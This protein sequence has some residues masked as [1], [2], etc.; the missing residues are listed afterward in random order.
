MTTIVTQYKSEPILARFCIDTRRMMTKYMFFALFSFIKTK[1]DLR[2]MVVGQTDMIISLMFV[3]MV[4]SFMVRNMIFMKF[5]IVFQAMTPDL[6][7]LVNLLSILMKKLLQNKT[8]NFNIVSLYISFSL[9]AICATQ[10]GRIIYV[11]SNI[12]RTLVE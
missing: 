5:G 12:N 10:I 1:Q 8:V 6:F 4:I 3:W 9:S 2:A 7:L 11:I